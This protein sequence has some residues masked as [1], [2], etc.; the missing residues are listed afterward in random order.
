MASELSLNLHTGQ[1]SI[2]WSL[3]L[4]LASAST[5]FFIY[6]G[7]VM[8]RKRIKNSVKFDNKNADVCSHII[9]VGSE[10]G[11]TFGFA[12]SLESALKKSGKKVLVAQLNDYD[13]YKNAEHLFILT[14]TYGEGDPPTNAET[15]WIYW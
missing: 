2:G 9:L 13:V 11:T 12:K 3:V 14:A 8:W 10:T 7:F 15:F 4:L 6:S 5:L 1:G